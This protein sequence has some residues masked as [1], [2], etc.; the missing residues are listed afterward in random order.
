MRMLAEMGSIN[1]HRKVFYLPQTVI[2]IHPPGLFS[3]KSEKIKVDTN[4]ST[5]STTISGS[6]MSIYSIRK[7]ITTIAPSSC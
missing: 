1:R 2:A 7:F 3:Q 5:G 4:E 6:K